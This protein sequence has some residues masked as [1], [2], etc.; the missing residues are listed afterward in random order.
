MC[1]LK[2]FLHMRYSYRFRR[3]SETMSRLLLPVTVYYVNMFSIFK[4]RNKTWVF[5]MSF[6]H[7]LHYILSEN[8]F[9]KKYI[10]PLHEILRWNPRIPARMIRWSA[11]K[12]TGHNSITKTWLLYI[13]KLQSRSSMFS[14][15]YCNNISR[16]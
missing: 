2:I 3:I 8:W 10:L 9:L 12:H 14:E 7:W 16:L 5:S 4:F 13:T 1:T 11:Y 6:L 15:I